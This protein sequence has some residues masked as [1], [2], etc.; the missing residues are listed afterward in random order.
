MV[1][2]QSSS[3][4]RGRACPKESKMPPDKMYRDLES[5]DLKENLDFES[6]LI[7]MIMRKSA[8]EGLGEPITFDKFKRRYKKRKLRR[9]RKSWS[10]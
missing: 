8:H 2:E 1:A 7:F 4:T 5:Q 3:A 6:M 9:P 10:G